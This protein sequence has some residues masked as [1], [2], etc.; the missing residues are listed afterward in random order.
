M[1]TLIY[2]ML[3]VKALVFGFYCVLLCL[4]AAVLTLFFKTNQIWS[5]SYHFGLVSMAASSLPPFNNKLTNEDSTDIN[6]KCDQKITNIII[7]IIFVYE[8]TECCCADR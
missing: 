1:T 8:T 7:I 4:A 2:L 5:W 3:Y 6:N